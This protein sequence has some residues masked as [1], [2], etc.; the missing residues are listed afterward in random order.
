VTHHSF[1]IICHRAKYFNFN[2]NSLLI[3]SAMENVL[4][5]TSKNLS[6]NLRL[7]RFS[8]ILF[9]RSLIVLSYIFTFR[10]VIHFVL[11]FVGGIEAHV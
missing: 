3:T 10:S 2:D 9:C 7:S 11:V 6:Q 4:N 1:D 5:I 8:P